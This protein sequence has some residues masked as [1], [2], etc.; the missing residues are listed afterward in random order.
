[1]EAL[2]GRATAPIP[3][4]TV[5]ALSAEPQT[6]A[7]AAAVAAAPV[8]APTPGKYVPRH[9]HTQ[10]SSQAPPTDIDK[11]G[12][13]RGDDGGGDTWRSGKGGSSRSTW[14]SSRTSR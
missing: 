9:L 13:G 1:M 3:S 7:P 8:P 5:G 14:S 12:P 11:W 10:V 6:T 4:D 2:L